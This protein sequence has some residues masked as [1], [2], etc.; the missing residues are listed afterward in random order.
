MRSL[1]QAPTGI[2]LA[3]IDWG[4]QEIAIAALL[5]GDPELIR[6]YSASDPYIAFGQLAGQIPP[7]ATKHTH[8][9]LRSMFKVL[10]LGVNYGMSEIGLARRLGVERYVAQALLWTHQQMF[11]RFW[12]W[13][14]WESSEA[15]I[16]G[17]ITT[18]FGWTY[19]LQPFEKETLLQ[20]WPM[21]AHGAEMMRLAACFATE[22]G[23]RVCATVHDA[24]L[25]EA[26][27]ESIDEAIATT[28]EAMNA[29]SRVILRGFELKTDV[30]IIR[31]GE[32][33]RDDDGS[34]LWTIVSRTLAELQAGRAVPGQRI[35]S[36]PSGHICG[37]SFPPGYQW[38][39]R[40]DQNRWCHRAVGGFAAGTQ[41]PGHSVRG[42]SVTASAPSFLC[43]SLL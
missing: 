19:H 8:P 24:F 22:R 1:I 28:R 16:H 2:A 42:T 39:P 29:A 9:E 5:S 23:V 43:I 7:G 6:V 12:R 41:H 27:S 3:H 14:A 13:I 21:Q 38:E 33:Y 34:R 11:S 37:R 26:P 32:R 15:R 31:S 35:P 17:T 4:A 20:N 30:Q 25:V 10:M 40:P 36:R 18:K